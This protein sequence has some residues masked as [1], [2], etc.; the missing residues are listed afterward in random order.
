[1]EIQITNPNQM[2]NLEVILKAEIDSAI[3]T[4]KM[5]PRSITT[6]L[7]RAES[8]ATLSAEIA[9]SCTFKVPRQ[10]KTIEGKSVRFAEILVSQYQ[11]IKCG[12]RIV[13]NDGKTITA[14]GVCHDLE[15]NVSVSFEVKKTITKK[16]GST[17]SEDMQV[18]AGNAACAIA[19][20]NAVF[21]VIPSA[22]SDSIHDKV[23]KVAMGTVETLPARRKKSIEYLASK[24]VT[25]QQIIEVLNIKKINDIDLD[26]LQ[27]LRG[28]CVSIETGEC[29][30]KE[31]FEKPEKKLDQL[32]ENTPKG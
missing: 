32:F 4:A 23:K 28:I 10:G 14:Q 17:Y 6:F 29:T 2:N 24:G 13:A 11:N 8:I 26:I 15:N 21:K 18:V 30:A 1:M 20:R 19:F 3:S 31:I 5:Y 25:E 22:I 12:A 27:E 16:D 7:Q 9:E